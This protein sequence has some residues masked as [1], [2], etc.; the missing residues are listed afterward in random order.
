MKVIKNDCYGGFSLSYKAV[1]RYAELKGMTLYAFMPTSLRVYP[2][3]PWNGVTKPPLGLLFYCT[4]RKYSEKTRFQLRK[5]RRTDPALVQTVKELG[6][7]A[8]GKF[9][10]LVIVE[11]PDGVKWEIR[12]NDGMETIH[13]KHR[14]W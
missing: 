13:E 6:K 5:I 1:M 12:Y 9:A 4:T 3:I 10:K 8:N 2:P 7:K 14:T 11:V